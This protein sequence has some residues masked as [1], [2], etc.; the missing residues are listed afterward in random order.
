MTANQRGLEQRKN[1]SLPTSNQLLPTTSD[2]A[3]RLYFKKLQCC[4]ELLGEGGGTRT[5][6]PMIKSHALNLSV[7]ED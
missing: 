6:D 7:S 5:L 2:P 4:N 1:R 3:A